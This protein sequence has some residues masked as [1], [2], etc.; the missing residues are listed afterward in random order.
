M[1][2]IPKW[3][4]CEKCHAIMCFSCAV[5]HPES[6][7][8]NFGDKGKDCEYNKDGVCTALACYNVRLCTAKDENGHPQ[9][10]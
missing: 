8:I 9:Y 3:V 6:P 2:D 1:V 10:A 5:K 4:D 7:Y